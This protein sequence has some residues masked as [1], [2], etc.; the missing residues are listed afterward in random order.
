MSEQTWND[1]ENRWRMVDEILERHNL[2]STS[3][4]IPGEA[5]WVHAM[6]VADKIVEFEAEFE[7]LMRYVREHPPSHK[8]GSCYLGLS[9]HVGPKECVC[10]LTEAYQTLSDETRKRIEN[11]QTKRD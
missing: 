11:E 3:D 10:G 8:L 2:K 1:V 9:Y 7:K 4:P 6:D 5:D